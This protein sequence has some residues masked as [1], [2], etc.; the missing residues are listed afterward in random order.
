MAK[1]RLGLLNK[2]ESRS[3]LGQDHY[4]TAPEL[5]RSSQFLLLC[6]KH[7]GQIRHPSNPEE[8]LWPRACTTAQISP[9]LIL[10]PLRPL[11]DCLIPRALRDLL[12]NR[13]PLNWALLPAELP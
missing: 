2:V 8:L 1:I 5:F 6:F 4:K 13:A 9:I 11:I 12:W 10:I 3:L 7:A